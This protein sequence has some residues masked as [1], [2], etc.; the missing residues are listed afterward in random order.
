MTS[1][2][3]NNPHKWFHPH[4]YI[5]PQLTRGQ[6]LNDALNVKFVLPGYMLG[7]SNV[8]KVKCLTQQLNSMLFH[9]IAYGETFHHFFDYLV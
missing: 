2:P 4:F 3:E 7:R 9:I 6:S 5:T 8:R 1:S